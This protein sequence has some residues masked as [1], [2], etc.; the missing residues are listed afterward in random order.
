MEKFCINVLGA[1]IR[2]ISD[3]PLLNY[4]LKHKDFMEFYDAQIIVDNDDINY[5]IEYYDTIKNSEP[6]IVEKNKMIIKYPK[7]EL[8]ES[9]LLYMGFHFLEKQFAEQGMCSCHSACIEKNGEATL[10]VGEAG[11]GKT[12]LA[13]NMCSNCGFSLIS[14]DMT[15]IGTSNDTL[16][17]YG[18]TKFI[19]LRL[20]STKQNMPFLLH[21]FDKSNRDEWTN[22]ITIM[23]NDIGIESNYDIIKIKHIL[24]VHVDGR[25]SFTVMN[26]DSWRNNFLMYQNVSSHIRGSSATFIDR[27]GYPIAFIPSFD[28]KETYDLRIKML[29]MINKNENY[30]YISGPLDDIIEYISRINT[31][32]KSLVLERTRNEKK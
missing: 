5:T 27:R 24:F 30:R 26:G 29:N 21:L 15:L 7:E 8:T 32:E 13:V 18:G 6:L 10:L 4:F 3:V 16:F 1:K 2:Y 14:N 23:A 28:T 31:K 11:A 22:K 20:M 25:E 19:N 17:A 12:S 9:I